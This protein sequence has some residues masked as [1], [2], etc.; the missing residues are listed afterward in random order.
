MVRSHPACNSEL[1]VFSVHSTFEVALT[2][3]KRHLKAEGS[4]ILKS[5]LFALLG[6][7]NVLKKGASSKF[8]FV[9]IIV[10][11]NIGEFI[12]GND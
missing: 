1:S 12:Y 11:L 2:Q 4:D 10:S 7:E 6:L 8:P 9:S 5:P 3:I